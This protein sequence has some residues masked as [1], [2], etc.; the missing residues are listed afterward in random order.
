VEYF[1]HVSLVNMNRTAKISAKDAYKGFL[2]TLGSIREEARKQV[3]GVKNLDDWRGG[4]GRV[5][6]KIGDSERANEDAECNGPQFRFSLERAKNNFLLNR[7][8][9]AAQAVGDFEDRQ[10]LRDHYQ[11]IGLSV[12]QADKDFPLASTHRPRRRCR[13]SLPTHSNQ[14][15][16]AVATTSR[17]RCLWRK[18]GAMS[19]RQWRWRF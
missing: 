2:F 16:A 18:R 11:S 17:I 8:P 7:N 9:R 6:R 15:V 1:R 3:A 10:K 12:K 13:R 4:G 5:G 14:S 19:F